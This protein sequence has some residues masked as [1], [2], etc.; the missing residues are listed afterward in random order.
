MRTV[1][2]RLYPLMQL[3]MWKLRILRLRYLML[4]GVIYDLYLLTHNRRD[5]LFCLIGLRNK[6]FWDLLVSKNSNL[7]KCCSYLKKITFKFLQLPY[8]IIIYRWL[9][10]MQEN[11]FHFTNISRFKQHSIITFHLQPYM[12]S[13]PSSIN[14]WIIN[15]HFIIEYFLLY[16][17]KCM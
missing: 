10:N 8:V 7:K 3:R 11:S 6:K 14:Q 12:F 4:R 1:V 15:F 9:S 17:Y 2:P 13:H 5:S 16:H